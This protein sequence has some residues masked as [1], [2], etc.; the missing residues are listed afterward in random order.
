MKRTRNGATH[1]GCLELEFFQFF[2][3]L[4]KGAAVD[5]S[6]VLGISGI[7]RTHKKGWPPWQQGTIR[8]D[9]VTV[10]ECSTCKPTDAIE[11]GASEGKKW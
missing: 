5:E 3:V 1:N 2:H 4:K 7:F 6:E 11:P 8:G 10:P 9:P